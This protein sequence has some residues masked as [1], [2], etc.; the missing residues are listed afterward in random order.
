MVSA[1]ISVLRSRRDRREAGDPDHRGGDRLKFEPDAVI[2]RTQ[3]S[4]AAIRIAPTA[5]H[6]PRLRRPRA[7]SA[8]VDAGEPR[9]VRIAADGID[10]ASERGIAKQPEG[11]RIDCD[12]RRAAGRRKKRSVENRLQ[13][14][15]HLADGR[16]VIEHEA[17]A[18]GPKRGEH[19]DEE[20]DAQIGC[21]DAVH[22]PD[23][24][25]DQHRQ[26]DRRNKGTPQSFTAV[27]N[28]TVISAIADPER[29]QCRR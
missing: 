6:R 15:R 14:R 4:R 13:P 20:G 16:P 18:R 22:Q 12:H 1:P 17:D 8:Y 3:L 7:R 19:R 11:D 29:D 25:P 5:A 21:E 26:Q 10:R 23:H 9:G 27:A 2:R 28:T 24:Q